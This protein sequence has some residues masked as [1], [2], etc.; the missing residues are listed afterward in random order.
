[1]EPFEQQGKTIEGALKAAE[2]LIGRKLR[3]SEYTV[4]EAGS[5]GVLGLIGA[6]PSILKISPKD[7]PGPS[8][9]TDPKISQLAAT[10][11]EKLL[12][13]MGFRG[14]VS[15]GFSDKY[16]KVDIE[17]EE[18]DGGILIGRRGSTLEAFQHMLRRFVEKNVGTG[19]PI[20]VDVGGYRVR[21]REAMIQ[22]AMR[23]AQQVKQTGRR[24]TLD[25]MA[26]GERRAVHLALKEDRDISTYSV[27]SEPERK[28]VIAPAGGGRQTRRPQRTEDR[29]EREK[30]VV[31]PPREIPE[32]IP[33][34]PQERSP[35]VQ[36]IKP[37]SEMAYGRKRIYRRP[38]N[39]PVKPTSSDESR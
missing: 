34:Q 16:Y 20:V 18:D 38:R 29:R 3:E 21:R 6:R 19:V 33:E 8:K 7:L 4:V 11:A 32:Q 28:I 12:Q 13:H 27:G 26:P 31:S 24:I 2:E 30:R 36:E 15:V 22:R 9:D 39:R 25:P 17:I 10:G 5:R 37:P 14:E 23:S 35:S 1:M